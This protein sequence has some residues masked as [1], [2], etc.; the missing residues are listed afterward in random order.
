MLEKLSSSCA[1]FF[2]SLD[3]LKFVFSFSLTRHIS[4]LLPPSCFFLPPNF[5]LTLFNEDPVV[6]VV[7]DVPE[8]EVRV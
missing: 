1:T 6:S 7:A 4:Y 3:V 5:T 8:R 2:S